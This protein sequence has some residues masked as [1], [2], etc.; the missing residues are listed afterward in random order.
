[1]TTI[2]MRRTKKKGQENEKTGKNKKK[3]RKEDLGDRQVSYHF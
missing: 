2:F 1:M 3:K